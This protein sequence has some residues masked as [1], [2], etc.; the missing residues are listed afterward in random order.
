MPPAWSMPVD[1]AERPAAALWVLAGVLLVGVLVAVV[2]VVGQREAA[3]VLRAGRA[4]RYTSGG[5]TIVLPGLEQVRRIP[6]D[7]CTL[8]PIVA[9]AVTGDGIR[10]NLLC[11]ARLRVV[12]PTRWAATG[13]G[14]HLEVL[15]AVEATLTRDVVASELA[16]LV[17]Y[18]GERRDRLLAQ[19]NSV[20]H[21][22]GAELV[23]IGDAVVEV[24]VDDGLL[25][26]A[27]RAI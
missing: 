22:W 25:R 2:R 21:Q 15:H 9:R 11:S 20:V 5:L 26:W 23:D 27:H 8:D 6:L 4:V 1:G 12:E 10:V 19:T 18:P 24:S 3:V 13:P 7:D 16:G 17:N 14:S